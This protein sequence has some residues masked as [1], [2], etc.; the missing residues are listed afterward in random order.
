MALQMCPNQQEDKEEE[1]ERDEGSHL[2][3]IYGQWCGLCHCYKP[4]QSESTQYKEPRGFDLYSTDRFLVSI[5]N[6]LT[7]QII[8]AWCLNHPNHFLF[9]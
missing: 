2:T 1:K 5:P 3:F 9:A 4:S 8:I 6:Q 7:S